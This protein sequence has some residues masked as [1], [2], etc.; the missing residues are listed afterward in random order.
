M[1]AFL[2]RPGGNNV[3]E[4]GR[5]AALFGWRWYRQV[6]DVVPGILG[7]PILVNVVERIGRPFL[8]D[9]VQ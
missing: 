7:R 8:V 6:V 3:V 5:R 9:V 1:V 2:R 4:A